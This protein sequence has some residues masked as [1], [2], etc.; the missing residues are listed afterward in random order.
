MTL[1]QVE[2]VKQFANAIAE[3]LQADTD[4][5]TIQSLEGIE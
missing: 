4:P 1:E 5:D 2:L 3:I